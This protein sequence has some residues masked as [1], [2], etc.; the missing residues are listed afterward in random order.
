[1]T[2]TR[3]CQPLRSKSFRRRRHSTMQVVP[4]ERG[5]RVLVARVPRALDRVEHD[6]DV[7]RDAVGGER[8]VVLGG[9][10]R[11]RCAPAR[12]ARPGAARRRRTVSHVLMTAN[13]EEREEGEERREDEPAADGAAADVDAAAARRLRHHRR[14]SRRPRHRRRIRTS[15][16]RRRRGSGPGRSCTQSRTRA[17]GS[18][19][20]PDALP[21]WPAGTVCVLAT[22]GADGP[23]AIPVS[24]ALRAGDGRVVLALAHTRG[25]LARLR[26]DPRVALTVLA[27]P[28]LA[29]T[30]HG[31]A[32]VVADP[33]PGAEAVAG[34]RDHRRARSRGTSARRSRSTPAWRGA[35]P[36]RRR[37][38][39][40]GRC[41]RRCSPS[42]PH[43]LPAVKLA[44]FVPPG[45]GAPLAGEV[46]GDRV[47]AFDGRRRPSSTGSR[48]AT[49]RPPP[50]PITRSPTSRCSRRTSRARS[51]GSASTT[52]PTRPSR[53]RSR[54]RRR[55]SS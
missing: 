29:F 11:S 40:T 31:T 55:S 38:S 20:M 6:R 12:R 23:H 50:A 27:G 9:L 17:V 49:A 53:A 15:R 25:S 5:E 47:V 42:R 43:R 34:G 41:A 10:G 2:R 18:R 52:A 22:T 46:R 14:R 4:D 54:R 3:L 36:T 30:A 7:L 33:L 26:A 45:G 37:W 24:T 1:M 39:A 21:D 51:S 8:R 16:R 19:A 28:D 32:A 13:S 44:T 48:P 35:G